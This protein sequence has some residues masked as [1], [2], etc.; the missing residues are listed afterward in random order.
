MTLFR[1]FFLLSICLLLFFSRAISSV[2]HFFVDQQDTSLRRK[3][4]AK[5]DS[6]VMDTALVVRRKLSAADKMA[7]KQAAYKSIY[8]WGEIKNMVTLPHQGGLAVNLNKLYN[9]FSRQGRASRRLQKQFEQ[10]FEQDQILAYWNTLSE[11]Y[12]PLTGDSLAKFRIYYQPTLKW[13]KKSDHYDRIAYVQYSLKN[14]LDSVTI[15]HQRLSLP[16]ME[17][18]QP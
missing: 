8:F 9:L 11:S 5:R 1:L 7:E 16:R 13:L 2:P 10:E 14:Y 15:I 3:I 18:L 17:G 12:T 4:V 6:G